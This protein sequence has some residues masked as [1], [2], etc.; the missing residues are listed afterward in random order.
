MLFSRIFYRPILN[1]SIPRL[2]H[3]QHSTTTF[4][5]I[6]APQSRI[7]RELRIKFVWN[8]SAHQPASLQTHMR[9]LDKNYIIISLHQHRS[10]RTFIVS[11]HQ[12]RSTRTNTPLHQPCST[13]TWQALHRLCSTS[14]WYRFFGSNTTQRSTT[15]STIALH[16][17]SLSDFF[18]QN[19]TQLGIPA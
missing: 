3:T 2:S 10:I 1:A 14:K 12:H 18:Q 13:R 4:L 6:F 5:Q 11:L 15:I 19:L 7:S 9:L 17:I 16:A 8:I